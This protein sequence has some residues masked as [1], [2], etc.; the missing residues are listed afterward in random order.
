MASLSERGACAPPVTISSPGDHPA[1][2]FVQTRPATSRRRD[3][4]FRV[5]KD[6]CRS[7]D[8]AP[9]RL[10]TARGPLDD[11][12]ELELACLGEETARW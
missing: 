5:V 6:A 7:G 11:L 4:G 8:A 2:N 3:L 1:A 12:G 9:V 10:F